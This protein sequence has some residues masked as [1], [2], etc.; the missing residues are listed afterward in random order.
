MAVALIICRIYKYPGSQCKVTTRFA[1]SLTPAPTVERTISNLH[2]TL[3]STYSY[4]MHQRS[5]GSF[6]L[7]D[8]DPGDGDVG[9]SPEEG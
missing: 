8:S 2:Q 3:A 5:P 9:A 7:G 4:K 1:I 6:Q